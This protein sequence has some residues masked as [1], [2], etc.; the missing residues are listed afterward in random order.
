MS[1]DSSGANR[2]RA[3]REKLTLGTPLDP[4]PNPHARVQ[5]QISRIPR[6][7]TDVGAETI[8]LRIDLVGLGGVL[9]FLE[10]VA[11]TDAP[12]VVLDDDVGGRVVVGL[13]A[14]F[15]FDVGGEIR[16][17]EVGVLTAG[18]DR[19]NNC[20]DRGLIWT[21]GICVVKRGSQGWSKVYVCVWE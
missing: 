2:G 4:T 21:R 16:G 9:E 11:G 7:H 14:V 17:G 6:L 3:P 15:G 20:Q 12:A 18:L 8:G 5:M 10:D 19:Q 13:E 1:V